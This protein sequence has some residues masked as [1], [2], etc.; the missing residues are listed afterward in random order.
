MQDWEE[1]K[2]GFVIMLENGEYIRDI[3]ANGHPEQPIIYRT[4]YL[5]AAKAYKTMK[6][7]M[8]ARN[9][10]RALAGSGEVWSFYYEET[11]TKRELGQKCD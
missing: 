2:T 11:L 6:G 9:R 10:V 8:K 3:L 7:A 4:K 1:I 5:W